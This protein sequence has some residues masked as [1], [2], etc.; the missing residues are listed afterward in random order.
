LGREQDIE[1]GCRGVSGSKG[2]QFGRK[3]RKKSKKIFMALSIQSLLL[4]QGSLDLYEL[5]LQT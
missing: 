4:S 1:I 5:C 3:G 2:G